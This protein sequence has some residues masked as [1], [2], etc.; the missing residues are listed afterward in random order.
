MA[1][2]V[3][4]PQMGYDMDAGTLLR[5]L[6]NVGD[7]VERGEA[8]AEIET[9]KVNI[10]IESFDAGVLAR[11]LI[12]EGDTVP[13]G[14]T[15]AI[16]G[17]PGEEVEAPE[18]PAEQ[19]AEAQ[20]Q[21]EAAQPQQQ[22]QEAPA[23]TAPSGPPADGKAQQQ[24]VERAPGER[25]RASPLVRRLAAEHEIDLAQVQGTG[26]HGRIVKRDIQPILDGT[27][28]KPSREG[29]A[30]AVAEQP[31]AAPSAAPEPEPAAVAPE[32]GAELQEFSRIRQTIGK[33]MA[34]S[35][36]TAPHIFV[37][38]AIDMGA[39]M[40]L[41]KQMNAGIDDEESQLSVND[42]VV[43]ATALALRSYPNLN[44]AYVNDQREVHDRIDINIAVAIDQ[45]LISPFI[46][47]ADR[48][49]LGEIARKSKDLARRARN[50]QLRPDEYAGGTF[51]IS[52]MGMYGIEHF[53]A[54]IN[55]P[56]AGILAVGQAKME[57]VWNADAD[58]FEPHFMMRVTMSADH[59]LT[60]G[61][62]VALFLQELKN[63]LENPMRMLVG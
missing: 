24:V 51:T 5:W 56:Q 30:P 57:P 46:A 14:E 25:I 49:P 12:S 35:F 45:G 44:S 21:P 18:Q 47:E 26:P 8:I 31:E 1:K 36:R 48:A 61:A 23:A 55:P 32:A 50:G 20:A 38:T 60:D 22:E 6:K 9:D 15:I 13:V 11:T 40:D 4:M 10:E 43:K 19:P 2:N 17:D 41:R 52:N 39:A 16:I 33:R 3:L 37:T 28:P 34:E 58:E 59:R 7:P 63:L 53:T 62:E 54:I 42:L 29:A 27:Q